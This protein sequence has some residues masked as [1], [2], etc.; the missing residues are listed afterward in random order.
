MSFLFSKSS[1]EAG[2]LT[3]E[4]LERW[5]EKLFTEPEPFCG[6][7]ERP[8]LVHPSAQGTTVCANCFTPIEVA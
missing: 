6:S 5:A 4:E 1:E 2:V 7:K 8:H 3:R